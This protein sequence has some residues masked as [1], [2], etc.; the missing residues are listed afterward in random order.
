MWWALFGLL[1]SAVSA[2]GQMQ[3][4]EARADQS[5]IDAMNLE[6]QKEMNKVV[7]KQ[8][9]I[10]RID[11]Y[12]ENTSQNIAQFSGRT[13]KSVEAFMRAQKEAVGKDIKTIQ[14]QGFLQEQS[15]KSAVAAERAR[16]KA[17]YT[18]AKI[19]AASTLLGGIYKYGQTK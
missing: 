19:D 7:A 8:N 14:T 17:E 2:A 12:K 18:A 13:D 1:G 11:Q 15:D 9:M 5:R 3:A 16:G 4:A 6:N 10:A